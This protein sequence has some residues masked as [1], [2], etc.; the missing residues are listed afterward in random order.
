MSFGGGGSSSNDELIEQQKQ[1]AAKAEREKFNRDERLRA[2]RERI[3][4]MFD[5]GGGTYN[6]ARQKTWQAASGGPQYFTKRVKNRNGFN[7]ANP[8]GNQ[9]GGRRNSE[10]WE[11]STQNQPTYTTVRTQNP[12]FKAAG[13]YDTGG[14]QQT[15][16][17]LA[18][19]FY[20]NFKNS[21]LDFYQPE[22][23]R[24]YEDAQSQ[25][26][27]DL[28][29]RGL[30]RSSRAADAA[31]DLTREKAEADARVV[32]N[33]ENQTAGLKGDMSRAEQNA[34]SLLQQT[35]DPTSAYNAAQSEVNAIQNRAPDF[36]TMGNL[37]SAALQAGAN[38]KQAQDAR[39]YY[40]SI[41]SRGVYE[42][43]GKGY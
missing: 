36:S 17:G 8:F 10:G 35:E 16:Q 5:V 27:F 14:G 33:A 9:G 18:G 7:P 25:N 42:T 30:L 34:I 12:N 4:A 15:E 1:E 32:A 3:R 22:V 39:K 21:I 23:E 40:D 41:P 37:F 13:W 24:Q 29:R 6:D 2:G 26:L 28:A 19:D 31:G 38:Y 20:S 43:S 11:Y